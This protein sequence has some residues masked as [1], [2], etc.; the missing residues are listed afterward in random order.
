M[1]LQAIISKAL[2]VQPHERYAS[3][4]AL[5]L[6]LEHWLNGQPINALVDQRGYMF[7]YTLKRH[8]FII[9]VTTIL[10]LVLVGWSISLVAQNQTIER[11]KKRVEAARVKAQRE[12]ALANELSLFMQKMLVQSNPNKSGYR[13]Q[14]LEDVLNKSAQTLQSKDV[15]QNPRIKAT[16]LRV[17]ADAYMG[18][19]R[20]KKADALLT[21]ARALTPLPKTFPCKGS[22][23]TL[24]S[25]RLAFSQGMLF[26]QHG[27]FQKARAAFLSLLERCEKPSGQTHDEDLRIAAHLKLGAIYIWYM[28]KD[29]KYGYDHYEQAR[30]LSEGNT[31]PEAIAG[32]IH[33]LVGMSLGDVNW[34]ERHDMVNKRI[35]RALKLADRIWHPNHPSR[36]RFYNQLYFADPDITRKFEWTARSVE[37]TETIYGKDHVFV[38]HLLNDFALSVEQADLHRAIRLIR[39]S[40]EILKKHYPIAH[41]LRL[42]ISNN[43]ASMLVV[44]N[45]LDEAQRILEANYAVSKKATVISNLALLRKAQGRY[46]EAISLNLQLLKTIQSAKN[47]IIERIIV[48]N[49]RLAMLYELNNQPELSARYMSPDLSQIGPARIKLNHLMHDLARL[50]IRRATRQARLSSTR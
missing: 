31:H 21:Q 22:G 2:S 20:R 46:D 4:Q 14:S 17:M 43:Y 34:P 5:A 27:Q 26:Y 50:Q 8:R 35:K 33:A 24:E 11:E 47:P 42:S 3:A 19:G 23:S 30:L 32:L 48:L 1:E 10:I 15:L 29:N 13:G 6:D 41:P 44:D 40:H 45:Q 9:A 25:A 39:R 12:A 16:L 38:G 37:I 49:V 18:L 36:A 28:E 7:W